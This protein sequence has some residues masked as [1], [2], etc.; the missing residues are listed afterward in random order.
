MRFSRKVL[1]YTAGLF[2][3]LSAFMLMIVSMALILEVTEIIAIFEESVLKTLQGSNIDLISV[4]NFS[5]VYLLISAAITFGAGFSYF[6][7]A[8]LSYPVFVDRKRKILRV[9]LLNLLAFVW[10]WPVIFAIIAVYMPESANERAE[11]NITYAEARRK[12]YFRE[13]IRKD[14]RLFAM[15]VKINMLK[16]S[17]QKKEIT[18]EDYKKLLNDIITTGTSI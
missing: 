12:E 5:K 16:H 17:L 4:V 2:A 13:V 9:V 11:L 14:Q 7:F 3:M 18:E 8:K 1:F 10:V 15:T 6:I